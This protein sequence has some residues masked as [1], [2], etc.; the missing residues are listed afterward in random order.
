MPNKQ[1]SN[2]KINVKKKPYKKKTKKYSKEF[3]SVLLW[4]N[5]ILNPK[6]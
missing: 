3:P 4:G 6:S 2:N 5:L 1:E